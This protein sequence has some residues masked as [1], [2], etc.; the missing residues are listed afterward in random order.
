MSTVHPLTQWVSA[1]LESTNY[2][3]KF[4]VGWLVE[5]MDVSTVDAEPTGR[6]L[7]DREGGL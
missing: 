6:E 7:E 1:S 3:L 2:G 5:S 4:C